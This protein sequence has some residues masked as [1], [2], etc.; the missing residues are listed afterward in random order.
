MLGLALLVLTPFYPER[1]PG[2]GETRSPP[3]HGSGGRGLGAA[4]LTATG[5]AQSSP[6]ALEAAD[7]PYPAE[8]AR[9]DG[10]RGPELR[11][12]YGRSSHSCTK[13]M[14]WLKSPFLPAHQWV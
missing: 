7:A 1:K 14:K 11:A 12:G 4:L 10:A 8:R 6:L 2:A 13:E 3:R 9:G 5:T